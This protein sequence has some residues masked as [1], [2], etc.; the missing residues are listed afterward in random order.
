[1]ASR[2]RGRRMAAATSR[3]RASNGSTRLFYRGSRN[4]ALPRVVATEGTLARSDDR[5]TAA[6]RAVDRHHRNHDRA[7][8]RAGCAV[9]D[10]AVTEDHL[11][12][13]AESD[14]GDTSWQL[15]RRAED[16]FVAVVDVGKALAFDVSTTARKRRQGI[17][18]VVDHRNHQ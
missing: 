13:S 16:R 12:H 5:R 8:Q 7:S 1:A 18:V 2:P 10:V 14:V 6:M 3:S 9:A 17:A 11:H 15:S 4:T